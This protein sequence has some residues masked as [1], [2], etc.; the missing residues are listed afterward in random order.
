MLPNLLKWSKLVLQ[1]SLHCALKCNFQQCQDHDH[2]RLSHD[3]NVKF[4]NTTLL[5]VHVLFQM[6]CSQLEKLTQQLYS[7]SKK[8]E[9]LATP[10]VD[11][12]KSSVAEYQVRD[13]QPTC[14]DM[15]QIIYDI[16]WISI[17]SSHRWINDNNTFRILIKEIGRVALNMRTLSS[18]ELTGAK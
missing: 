7:L 17:R 13:K 4:S 14:V 11:G 16:I 12:V 10:S 9:L 15:H 3:K 1:R 5:P 6:F 18:I 2:G 8:M